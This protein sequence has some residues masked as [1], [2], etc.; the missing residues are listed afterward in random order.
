MLARSIICSPATVR[1]GIDAFI[2][3]TG[4]NEL[5]IVLDVYNRLTRLHFIVLYSAAGW[6]ADAAQLPTE[7]IWITS[8]ITS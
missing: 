7:A 5:M 2:A 8:A 4:A 6:A 3:E 1:D